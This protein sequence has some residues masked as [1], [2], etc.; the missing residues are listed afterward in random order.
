MV[1][2][3]VLITVMIAMVM[4]YECFNRKNMYMKTYVSR[5]LFS[6]LTLS[7]IH[8]IRVIIAPRVLVCSETLEVVDLMVNYQESM[9]HCRRYHH[10]L[11]GQ[12]KC[13][14]VSACVIRLA[15]G[16]FE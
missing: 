3:V 5:T 8:R 13:L 10:R 14:V 6:A 9:C 15:E 4:R 11:H 16:C 1:M 2:I 7:A 12:C